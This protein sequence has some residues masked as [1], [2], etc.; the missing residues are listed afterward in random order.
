MLINLYLH[1][2]DSV[3]WALG[4]ASGAVCKTLS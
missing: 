3:S 4:R 2:F 1:C